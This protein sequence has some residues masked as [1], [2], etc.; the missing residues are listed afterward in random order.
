MKDLGLLLFFD[1]LKYLAVLALLIVGYLVVSYSAGRTL[2]QSLGKP[3]L[4]YMTLGLA[5]AI[6][7]GY[8][9]A[10]IGAVAYACNTAGQAL[11]PV[12]PLPTYMLRVSGPLA[13][14]I[15]SGQWPRTHDFNE[16]RPRVI[17]DN[18]VAAEYLLKLKKPEQ[19]NRFFN[20]YKTEMVITRQS[21]E[22]VV[23]R[24]EEFFW[25]AGLPARFLGFDTPYVGCSQTHPTP[26]NWQS[27]GVGDGMAVMFTVRNPNPPPDLLMPLQEHD[28]SFITR[29]LKANPNKRYEKFLGQFYLTEE[30]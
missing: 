17:F 6:P 25:V 2:G 13:F 11:F 3:F 20:L 9:L 5:I 27:R 8:F 24:R 30:K 29:T 21:D 15:Y 22:T 26:Q 10:C 23:A 1:G 16:K 19:Q 12:Q 7:I 4:K 28:E 18:L 14:S